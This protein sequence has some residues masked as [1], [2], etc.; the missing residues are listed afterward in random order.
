[1]ALSNGNIGPEFSRIKEY[2]PSGRL[3]VALDIGAN[4]GII[5]SMLATS[6]ET[7]HS[8]EPNPELTASWSGAVP[9]NV[10]VHTIALSDQDGQATLK[11]PRRQGVELSGW[12]S[13]ETPGVEYVDDMRLV[14][15]ESE[16]LIRST[17]ASSRLISSK[18]MSKGMNWPS[19]TEPKNVSGG[20]NRGWSWKHGI[21]NSSLA[22]S[23]IS[24]TS[25]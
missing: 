24:T 21:A 5:T 17:C 20:G 3:G 23:P 18:S 15:V 11:I 1:L 16:R 6:F 12:A 19:L 14:R 13:L 9:Q 10:V 7:V 25:H 22:S 2:M 8:F 4:R